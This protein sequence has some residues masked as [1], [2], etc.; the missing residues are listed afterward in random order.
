MTSPLDRMIWAADIPLA[1]KGPKG[2]AQRCLLLVLAR[3]V[4]LDL[5][6]IIGQ[7]LLKTGTGLS[8]DSLGAALKALEAQGLIERTPRYGPDGHTGKIKRLADEYALLI[9]ANPLPAKVSDEAAPGAVAEH[10][11]LPETGSTD[12][13]VLPES[14]GPTSGFAPGG[15]EIRNA[16]GGIE[17]GIEGGERAREMFEG[18]FARMPERSRKGSSAKS[19]H[20]AWL[21]L[22]QP[23]SIDA[24]SG[25]VDRWAADPASKQPAHYWISDETFR[26]FLPELCASSASGTEAQWLTI[27][28]NWLGG[29]EL[30]ASFGMPG[31]DDSHIPTKI[32]K[33]AKELKD[34]R[35]EVN[36]NA[37]VTQQLTTRGARCDE[38]S[39]SE[40]WANFCARHLRSEEDL[41]TDLSAA[42]LA[43]IVSE[44]DRITS[45]RFWK[46]SH[47]PELGYC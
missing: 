29:T 39:T 5:K 34:F 27:L 3:R 1:A 28:M 42:W 22:E 11:V 43:H 31:N 6:C 32:G 19:M 4:G 46:P 35:G 36:L 38:L 41:P 33:R 25:A 20:A 44:L 12:R 2:C 14:P 9:A 21:R 30:P 24:L 7:A 8:N 47:T 26:E 15:P 23:V 37:V 45:R 40:A 18:L 17:G 13:P 10:P 16:E